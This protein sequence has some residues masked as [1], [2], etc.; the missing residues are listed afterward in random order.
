MLQGA[1]NL[2]L[3]GQ[4]TVEILMEHHLS[5]KMNQY[6]LIIIPECDY[7]DAPFWKN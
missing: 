2:V 4:Y 1:L 7:L 3:D 6:P 5:G